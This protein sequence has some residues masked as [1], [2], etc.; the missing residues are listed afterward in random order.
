MKKRTMARL[1]LVVAAALTVAACGGDEASGGGGGDARPGGTLYILTMQEQVSHLDPQRNYTGADLGFVGSTMQRTL[2]SY[3]FAAGDAGSE[4]VADL[5]TDTGTAADGGKTWTFTLRDG[6]TFEDGSP[7]T[8]AD[9][10][11]GVSRTFATDVITDG[12]TYAISYLDIPADGYPGPYTAT[13]D[14][15][16]LFDKAVECS[17]DGKTVTFRLSQ[18]VVDFNY[19]VTLL[20]FSPVPKAKDTGEKYDTAPVSSGPYKIESYQPGKS[21]V[22]VRNDKWNRDSDPLRKAYPDKIEYQFALESSVIDERFMA[23][24]GDDQFAISFDG[25]QPENLPTVFGDEKFASRRL[26]GYDPYVSFTAFNVAAVP[27]VEVRKAVYLALDREALRTLS[28]GPYTGDFADGFVKPALAADYAK[29]KMPDGL[30]ADGTPNVDAAKAALE[31][32][33]TAC[34]D[35]Y[36]WAT[37]DGLKRY[38]ADSPVA[39]KA[40]AIWQ[41][42]MK[43]AGIVVVPEPVEAS[44]YYATVLNPETPYDLAGAGWGPDWANASTV[45]PELFTANGGFNLTR[46]VDDPAYAEFQTKVDAARAELDRAKQGKMWQELNQYVVDQ[47]WALPGSFTKAQDL[48]GSKVGNVYRWGPFGAINPGDVYL[49]T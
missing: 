8:C 43:A 2:T 33:K 9:I 25:L 14:Q 47:L 37:G 16:A 4:L 41:E 22:L 29:S 12:P 10:A 18:P 39:Q 48:W 32:A 1:G 13:A 7:I 11:Y 31:A 49:M 19:T 26:D 6:V 5:A 27:C 36:V 34:P 38:Y 24:A 40:M 23:D 42:S 21:L 15:Q 17:A 44:Q 35:V 20:A 30:N 45:L 28:G 3:R 46:N